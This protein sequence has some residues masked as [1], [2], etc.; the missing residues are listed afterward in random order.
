M[1]AA[2]LLQLVGLAVATGVLLAPALV[3]IVAAMLMR[4]WLRG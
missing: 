1:T 3:V 2:H 4:R